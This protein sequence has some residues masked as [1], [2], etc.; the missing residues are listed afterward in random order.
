MSDRLFRN[1]EEYVIGV[2]KFDHENK[3][4]G[5]P[6]DP[7]QTVWLNET[8]MKLTA[9]APATAEENPF[10][11]GSL[12]EV[13]PAERSTDTQ[14]DR[15][16][17]G[18]SSFEPID[19]PRVEV[20]APTPPPPSEP[21]VAAKEKPVVEEETGTQ[22]TEPQP[23]VHGGAEAEEEVATPA[24]KPEVEEETGEAPTPVE[25]SPVEDVSAKKARQVEDEKAAAEK[26]DRAKSEKGRPKGK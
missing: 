5:L 24:A 6:L 3:P 1:R 15:P 26:A 12:E 9:N 25:P 13:D 4:K 22:I 23:E 10:T 2:I 20:P 16:V 11:K 14:Q 18:P 8:E 7:Q 21:V 19:P 17:P